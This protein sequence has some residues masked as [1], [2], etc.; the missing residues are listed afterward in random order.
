METLFGIFGACNNIKKAE[1]HNDDDASEV[2]LN[3]FEFRNYRTSLDDAQQKMLERIVNQTAASLVKGKTLQV[4]NF[5]YKVFMDKDLLVLEYQNED[6]PLRSIIKMSFF[7]ENEMQVP[8]AGMMGTPWGLQIDFDGRDNERYLIFNFNDERQRLNF[9][10]TLRILRTR[11]PFLDPAQAMEIDTREDE[12][13]DEP[14]TFGKVLNTQ[15]YNIEDAGIPIIFSIRNLNLFQKLRSTSRHVYLEFF[16]RYPSQDKFLY[17]KSPTT[18]I[19]PQVLQTEDA[20]FKRKKEKK[21]E[22]GDD[23]RKKDEEQAQGDVIL[24]SMKF[25]LKNVKMKIPKVPHQIFGRLMAKDDYFPTAVGT[26]EFKVDKT[27]LQDRTGMNQ[28][29]DSGPKEPVSLAI[30]LKSAMKLPVESKD[31]AAGKEEYAIQRLGLL[32]I[33]IL[34]LVLP[35]ERKAKDDLPKKKRG[36]DRR[37]TRQGD[38]VEVD[39][40]EDEEEEEEDETDEEESEEGD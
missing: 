23:D 28:K 25:E 5:A 9:A 15:H 22:H 2:Q 39:D 4:N 40:D 36:K 17:A 37:S 38:F 6:Y 30:E 16:V 12:I 35:P 34:G 14:A 29:E 8:G 24:T 33:R 31:K 18:H 32:N 19:P 13:E 27:M 3:A 26:F 21:D 10:L 20:A 11:D 1:A 7:T